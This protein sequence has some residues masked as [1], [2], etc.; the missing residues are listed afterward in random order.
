MQNKSLESLLKLPVGI[1]IYIEL[2]PRRASCICLTYNLSET[3]LFE[4][5]L[6]CHLDNTQYNIINIFI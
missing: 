4:D 1:F 6:N 2:N 3:L 5:S